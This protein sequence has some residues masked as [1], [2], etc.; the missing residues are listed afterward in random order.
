[1]ATALVAGPCVSSAQVRAEATV[2]LVVDTRHPGPEIPDDFSG[3]S[4]EIEKLLADKT[5]PAYFSQGNRALVET[6]HNLGVKSLRVGGNTADRPTL[7]VPDIPEIDK[8]FSFARA[9][10]ANVIFTFR[11][12]QGGPQNAAPIARYLLDHYES[13]L[14]CFEVGNEPDIYMKSYAE[15]RAELQ[16]YMAA[17]TQAG[18]HP[19]GKFC[20][21]GTTPSE[22]A[23]AREFAGD[24]GHSGHIRFVTQHAYPGNSGRNVTD[25]AAGRN[26]VLSQAWVAS[27]NSFYRSFAR[28]AEANHLAYR[29]EET[30]SYF[31]GGAKDVSN[32]FAAA[33]WALDYMHWWALHGAAGVNFHTGDQVAAGD[34]TAQCYYAVFLSSGRGYAI[35]PLGYAMKAFDLGGHGRIVPIRILSGPVN[36]TAY[37]VL[38][39]DTA[40]YLTLVNK[41]HD[42]QAQNTIVQLNLP[43]IC[44]R[45]EFIRLEDRSGDVRDTS[46]LLLGH[47]EIQIN[48]VWNGKWNT[49]ETGSIPGRFTITV[50]P[51]SATI[52]KLMLKSPIH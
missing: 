18:V 20:G 48:G 50:P 28:E 29:I 8:L 22:A 38:A 32:T 31:N 46:G 33:L 40:L 2:K 4:F 14:T 26:A 37:G 35:Q 16:R 45:A 49:F 47:A 21:P 34:Q 27:Y 41:E 36:L 30:N 1:M 9:A 42:P 44:N 17:F 10:S 39:S 6:F 11:L 43:A 13:R 52:L 51:A 25:A 24:F 19:N 7:P 5:G 23:W 12:R 15:Y 3:L